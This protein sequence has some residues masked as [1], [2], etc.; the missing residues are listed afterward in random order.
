MRWSRC[1]RRRSP[2][3]VIA[4]TP[5]GHGCSP[6]SD[7][8]CPARSA[9]RRHALSV[10]AIEIA[11]R[12][13][14]A[15]L[16]ADV[17][18][19]RH[20]SS[21]EPDNLAERIATATEI[22]RL[23]EGIG[24]REVALLGTGALVSDLIEQGDFAAGRRVIAAFVRGAEEIKQ[25]RFLEWAAQMQASLARLE[26][27]FERR[28]T[29]R[30]PG[31]RGRGARPGRERA[32]VLRA[33]SNGPAALYRRSRRQ[34]DGLSRLRGTLSLSSRRARASGHGS[35]RSSAAG[36]RS[37]PSSR[38]WPRTTSPTCRRTRHF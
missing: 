24:D 36:R 34:R 23:A 32:T 29:P 4:R 7:G 22:V 35:M 21:W 37:K 38:N 28:R 5:G 14:D 9:E 17:L 8:R 31:A 16:L 30:G 15:G 13:G 19:E 1:W 25:P 3:S 2:P 27:R 26:G 20:Y 18:W 10:E 12:V 6:G 11:R 33:P